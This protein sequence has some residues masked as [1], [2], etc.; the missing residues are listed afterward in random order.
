M[1]FTLIELLV[2]IS[3]IAILAGLLLPALKSAR[4]K[5]VT[6]TC[7]NNISGIYKAFTMY[8]MD[9][10]DM[11]FWGDPKNPGPYD[12]DRY[13]YGGRSTGNWYSGS[14]GDLFNHYIPRPLNEYMNNHIESFRCPRD[15]QPSWR[16]NDQP[17]YEQ[18]GNSYALN[19][20]LCNRKSSSINNS[21]QVILFTEASEVDF[22]D[23]VFWHNGKANICYLDGHMSFTIVPIQEES[24]PAWGHE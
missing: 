9:F 17:K 11:I 2:V 10:D 22:P 20:Y 12:M 13:V 1:P 7:A 23:E 4:D 19:Y 16:W 5:A 21:S 18:V 3:V 8:V 14:Q 15:T 24:E 6:T